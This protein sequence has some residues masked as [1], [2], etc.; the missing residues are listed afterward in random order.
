[1]TAPCGAPGVNT[2]NFDRRS[3]F[4]KPNK[5]QAGMQSDR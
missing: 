1:M 5:A 4:L 2:F 3:Q